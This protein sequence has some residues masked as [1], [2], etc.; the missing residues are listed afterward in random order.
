MLYG[1]IFL[2]IVVAVFAALIYPGELSLSPRMNRWLYDR[3]AQNYQDKWRAPA[4]AECSHQA[5]IDRHIE[6]CLAATGIN[7]VLDLGCGTGRAIRLSRTVLESDIRYTGI[8]FSGAMLAQFQSWLDCSDSGLVRRVHLEQCELGQWASRPDHPH[9]GV[10]FLLEVG[11][12]LPSLVKVIETVGRVLP[13]GGGLVM[14]R[15]AHFWWMFFPKRRQS[16]R[17]LARLLVSAGF[18]RPRFIPW[19]FRYEY[20][21]ATKRLGED[22]ASRA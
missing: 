14:T 22:E 10:V 9:Y 18:E 17:A 16:R 21:L 5:G 20:V 19:R 8:D 2:G 7:A 6:R 15:P 13:P 4:Y 3:S 12:F 11:E 1:L